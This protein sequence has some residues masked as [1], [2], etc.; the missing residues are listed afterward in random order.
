MTTQVCDRCHRLTAIHR[1][2]IGNLLQ[3]CAGCLLTP[4]CGAYQHQYIGS[5]E[6]GTWVCL[7]CGETL[8]SQPIQTTAIEA[9]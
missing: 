8:A 9:P 3:L 7:Q 4:P 5:R 6:P 1:C 2:G